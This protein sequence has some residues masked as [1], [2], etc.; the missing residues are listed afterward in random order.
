MFKNQD[1]I[2]HE[3]RIGHNIGS[4]L[5]DGSEHLSRLDEELEL[6]L[7]QLLNKPRRA[8]VKGSLPTCCS[9]M[10]KLK[11]L[12]CDFL[13]AFGLNVCAVDIGF[14]RGGTWSLPSFGGPWI[15]TWPV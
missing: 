5:L 11:R 4:S 9:A 1:L 14:K 10:R 12:N 6:H 15:C 13:W 7:Y 8:C 2:L 3:E